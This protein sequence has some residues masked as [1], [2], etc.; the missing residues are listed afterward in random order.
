M[1]A[2]FPFAS[3]IVAGC[4][5]GMFASI[6]GIA[7]RCIAAR[8]LPHAAAT[9]IGIVVG[10]LAGVY[11]AHTPSGDAHKHTL[12]LSAGAVGALLPWVSTWRIL[13]NDAQDEDTADPPNPSTPSV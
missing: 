5:V 12:I 8:R 2:N 3:T 10:C 13:R 1:E 9:I 4:M 11:I 7:L 6:A